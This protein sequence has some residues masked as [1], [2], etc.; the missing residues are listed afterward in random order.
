VSTAARILIDPP[1]GSTV[2]AAR[3]LDAT[4]GRVQVGSTVDASTRAAITCVLDYVAK[5]HNSP[6][7]PAEQQL[8]RAENALERLRLAREALIRDGYFTADQVGPDVAPR[9]VEWLSHHRGLIETL[10]AEVARLCAGE[11]P[12]WDPLVVPTPGQWIARWNSLDAAQRLDR[13][14]AVIEMAE[15][16]NR[17]QFDGHRQRLEEGWQAWAT[18]ARVRDLRDSWLLMTLEPGQVRRLLDAITHALDG[19]PAAVAG[20]PLTATQAAAVRGADLPRGS[21]ITREAVDEAVRQMDA[22]PHGLHTGMVVKPYTERGVQ[23]WVFRCWGTDACDGWLSL[24]HA[25]ENSAGSARDRH[26]VEAHPESVAT[27]LRERRERAGLL[28]A[29]LGEVLAAFRSVTDDGTRTLVGYVS[30]PIH[31]TDMDRWR[32]ALNPPKE[33]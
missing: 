20:Q 26:L 10:N 29:V 3:H 27:A 31:P 22:D 4:E 2:L 11:E 13:A 16:A 6:S 7:V 25:S 15:T 32:A 5:A 18:V 19:Q 21:R 28:G 23:R 24:D 1:D 8:G 17:C 33:Q 9:I 12:G 30:A 14:K